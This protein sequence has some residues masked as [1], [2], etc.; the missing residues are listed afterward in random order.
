[1][2]MHKPIIVDLD[3]TLLKSDLLVELFCVFIK[4]NPLNLLWVAFWLF[5]GK[6]RLK[7][8]LSRAVEL[9]VR[10]LPYNQTVIAWL[11]KHKAEGHTM[12][13][14]TA[15]NE[16]YAEKICAHIDLFDGYWGSTETVNLSSRKKRDLLNKEIG[17]GA[18]IYLGNSSDDIAVWESCAEAVVVNPDRGVYKAASRAAIVTECIETRPAFFPTLL[19]HLRIHQWLKN[20]LV[21]V[22]LLASHQALQLT[23]VFDAI[24]AFVAFGL[25]ASGVY[26]INDL[27]DLEADR[28][29]HSKCFRPLA[30]GDFC[31]KRAVLWLPV[32][33]GISLLLALYQLP[34]LFVATLS[35]YFLLTL[36][37]SFWLKR[38]VMVDVISLA[39]LYTV[40]IVAGTTALALELSFWLLAFSMFIFLSLALIKRY[41]EIMQI[42]SRGGLDK[43]L[44]RGYV[45]E[46]LHLLSSLGAASGYISVLVLALYI[47]DSRTLELYNNPQIIWFSCPLLLYWVSRVWMISH[48]GLMNDDPIVWAIKDRISRYVGLLFSLVFV[49]AIL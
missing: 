12:Y 4:K 37:Y 38:V 35:F 33:L 8:E 41:A 5:K 9:D 21:F 34:V 17:E 32:L 42:K 23:I 36:V 24:I 45:V 26:V 30:S 3:G 25:C 39:T 6:A 15:S 7:A 1:M 43:V 48:R 49:L 19:K 20:I 14:A 44:G 46:D 22:P 2:T 11:E 27:L 18:Y 13:L 31:I 29:H 28:S 40:R 47:Q 10:V 16:Q